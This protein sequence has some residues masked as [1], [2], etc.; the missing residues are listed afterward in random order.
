MR[1]IVPGDV[2][3]RGEKNVPI[4][5]RHCHSDGREDAEAI[6]T[7]EASGRRGQPGTRSSLTYAE[8]LRT[9]SNF[10][11]AAGREE[12]FGTLPIG[13]ELTVQH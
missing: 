2:F 4:I 13:A 7:F 6:P 10:S 9:A 8:F 11:R 5:V 12:L 1:A 3:L